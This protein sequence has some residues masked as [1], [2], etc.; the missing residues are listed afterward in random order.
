MANRHDVQH[1][2]YAPKPDDKKNAKPSDFSKAFAETLGVLGAGLAF[3]LMV[4]GASVVL[5]ALCRCR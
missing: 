2:H 1:I 3:V 4:I 5:Q